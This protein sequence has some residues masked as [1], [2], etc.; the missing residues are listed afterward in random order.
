M[1]TRKTGDRS[2]N[3]RQA[4]LRIL[5]TC[6]GRRVELLRA[7]H[8]AAKELRIRLEVHGAD[9]TRLS[10]GFHLVD[11]PHLVPR[12]DSGEYIDALAKLVQKHKIDLLIPLLDPELPLIAEAAPRFAD[13]GCRAVISSPAVVRICRDK[14]E[15]HR[16]LTAAGIDTP[17][18]WDWMHALALKKHR[19][20]YYMKPRFGSAGKGNYVISNT[21]ELRTLGQRVPEPIVQEY[22]KGVEHTLDVYTGFDGKPRC[23]V[24]RR[25]L[26]VRTGEVSKGLIVKDKDLM[27][28]GHRVAEALGECRGVVTVQCI[29]TT[30]GRIRAIEINPRLGGGV[31]LAIHAGADF[32]KWLLSEH[33]GRSVRINATGFKGDIAMLR[34]DDSVFVPNAT[35]RCR[36]EQQSGP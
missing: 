23:V 19:F 26:E 5:F 18:T 9:A 10:P 33:L 1:P 13:L 31:P 20:P 14:L 35:R 2:T 7:F 3:A 30:A 22:V 17:E 28:L 4:T 32:P 11:H 29:K 34:F 8:R 25:R 15:T 24:P 21:E 36:I 12:I 27:Q 16:A 6:I